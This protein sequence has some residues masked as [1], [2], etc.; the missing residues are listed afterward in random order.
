MCTSIINK[1]LRWS[2]YFTCH[3]IVNEEQ[4]KKLLCNK[5]C[6]YRKCRQK[7]WQLKPEGS[8]ITL[9]QISEKNW[10]TKGDERK[11]MICV[12]YVSTAVGKMARLQTSDAKQWKHQAHRL[13][14]VLPPDHKGLVTCN[15]DAW[16]NVEAMQ[17][18]HDIID[19]LIGRV[20]LIP[21]VMNHGLELW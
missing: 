4:C 5:S 7:A 18:L 11:S 1:E 6:H 19:F 17:R 21:S 20:D 10:N 9:L 8:H 14:L 12:L 13:I 3:S 16:L 2:L 15:T